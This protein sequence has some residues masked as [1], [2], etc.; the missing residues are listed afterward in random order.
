MKEIALIIQLK[1]HNYV[2]TNNTRYGINKMVSAQ[3]HL[4]KKSGINSFA[5]Y[6]HNKHTHT[7]FLFTSFL[8][9]FEIDFHL[10][11]KKN[12][13]KMQLYFMISFT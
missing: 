3:F 12:N 13:N 9:W 4:K 5:L 8:L 11:L 2:N 10:K 7:L 6:T 1:N